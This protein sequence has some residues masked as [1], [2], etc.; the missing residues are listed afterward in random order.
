LL[1]TETTEIGR[2]TTERAKIA[3]TVAKM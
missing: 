1:Y 3:E 2:Q